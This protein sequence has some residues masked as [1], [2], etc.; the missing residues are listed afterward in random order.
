MI[1]PSWV[2]DA[3]AQLPMALLHTLW[4]GVLAVLVL[5]VMLRRIPA[6][7]SGAALWLVP[8]GACIRRRRMAGDVVG[9]G[10]PGTG[11]GDCDRS[12]GRGVGSDGPDRSVG[13]DRSNA[14]GAETASAGAY[15][16]THSAP[17]PWRA[18][19]ADAWLA[20]VLVMA[21]RTTLLV[22]G[23]GRLRRGSVL[24]DNDGMQSILDELREALGV[25]GDVALR[26][27]DRI[28]GP[29]VMGILSPAILLP[30]YVM[31]GV[32][33]DHLRA[34]LA[35]ELAHIRR[36]DYLVNLAQLLVETLLVLQSGGVVDQ[37]SDSRRAGS[38]L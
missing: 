35:H 17:F 11:R 36:Y 31:T 9:A 27:S 6:T 3:W 7:R 21:V 24:C 14:S 8:G 28:D 10:L 30:A 1:V 29:M 19:L 15:E 23:A 33:P 16:P 4:Q 22:R 25:A 2:F 20:G 38:V 32:P 12:C 18:W 26:V 34:A 5:W 13:S 37:P